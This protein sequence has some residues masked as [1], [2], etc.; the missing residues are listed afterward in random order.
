MKG[1]LCSTVCLR[2]DQ[3]RVLERAIMLENVADHL[4]GPL[5]VASDLDEMGILFV[6]D[7]GSLLWKEECV[8]FPEIR[9]FACR[10]G[11]SLQ[12]MVLQHGELRRANERFQKGVRNYVMD[13]GSREAVALIQESGVQIA[14]LLKAHFPEEEELI[15]ALADAYLGPAQDRHMLDLFATTEAHLAWCFEELE[16]FYPL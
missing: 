9:P 7:F 1:T 15:L 4:D 5:Q 6:K 2:E 16:S 8:L 11:T 13:P 3:R 14:Q 12:E 10:E